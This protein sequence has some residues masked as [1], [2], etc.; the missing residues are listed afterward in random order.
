MARKLSNRGKQTPLATRI[1]EGMHRADI[2]TIKELENRARVP[3]DSVRRLLS[4]RTQ[5]PRSAKLEPIAQALGMTVAELI[6]AADA[7]PV[8]A[9][10]ELPPAFSGKETRWHIVADDAMM[11]TLPAGE[12]VLVDFSQHTV[13]G[14]G[15]YAL[16]V[17][18]GITLRRLAKPITGNTIKVGVDN[19]AYPAEGDVAPTKMSIAGRVIGKLVRV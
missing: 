12:A 10:K 14:S 3:R 1:R 7:T 8:V 15:V 17:D 2:R 11:P 16:N 13:T 4:G 18:G 6:G 19:P 5:E 9:N